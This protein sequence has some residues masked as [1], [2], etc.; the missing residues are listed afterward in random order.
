[1]WHLQEH[2]SHV[3]SPTYCFPYEV[4]FLALFL[5]FYFLSHSLSDVSQHF[6]LFSALSFSLSLS[7][8]CSFTGEWVSLIQGGWKAVCS[9]VRA[10]PVQ[11][12]SYL[13]LL[14]P[15]QVRVRDWRYKQVSYHKH[16][17]PT[18]PLTSIEKCASFIFQ[19]L[20]KLL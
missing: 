10:I 15:L 3:Q 18:L 12:A 17:K 5:L 13:L 1:M 16:R 7:L 14:T 9:V 2:T 6:S 19:F 11:Q 4:H 8:T 20:A